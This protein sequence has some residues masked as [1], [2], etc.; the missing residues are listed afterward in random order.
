MKLLFLATLDAILRRGSFTAAAEEIG[1]TPSAVSLQ[2]KRLEE[3]LGQPLFVRSGRVAQPTAVARQL[4]QSTR[5]ALTLLESLRVKST[6]AVEG[7]V[8]LGTIRTVQSSTLLPAL[9]EVRQ[10][11]PQLVVRA[12]HDDSDALLDQL[13]KGVIDAAVVIKPSSRGAGRIHWHALA[14]EPFVLIA[15]PNSGGDSLGDL[16]RTHDWIQFDTALVSGRMA[17]HYLR[18]IAPRARGA[19]EIDSI[20]TIVALVSAGAGVSVVPKPRHPISTVHPVREIPLKTPHAREIS[21]AS[22]ALD[23]DNRRVIALREAFEFAYTQSSHA[24]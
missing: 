16:L 20:D 23:R 24:T 13:K 1:L 6:P 2:V 3:H 4:A 9:L 10:R 15:P 8:A 5:E 12:T 11:F 22:R 21:F 7:R 17:A 14:H 18:R 19:V